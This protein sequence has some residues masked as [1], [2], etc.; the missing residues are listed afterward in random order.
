MPP[1]GRPRKYETSQER[2]EAK[3]RYQRKKRSEEA[4]TTQ[5]A[6]RPRGR[7]RKERTINNRSDINITSAA[8][9][10]NNIQPSRATTSSVITSNDGQSCHSPRSDGQNR[11]DV[12]GIE[13]LIE[14]LTIK[15]EG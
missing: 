9:S 2:R 6:P 14:L 5:I 3:T 13:P 1:R 7:P 15:D 4:A 10:E 11:E 8:I 12:S